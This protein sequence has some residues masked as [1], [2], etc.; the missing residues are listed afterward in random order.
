MARLDLEEG[1][2]S[3][4]ARLLKSFYHFH[5]Q[6]QDWKS[7]ECIYLKNNKNVMTSFS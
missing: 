5:P 2:I 7:L 4:F 3:L 6:N 1:I